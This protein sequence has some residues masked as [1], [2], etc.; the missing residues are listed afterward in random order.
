M[1]RFTRM[2][3]LIGQDAA[4]RLYRAKVAV[5]GLGGVGGYVVEALARAG[6]GT[7]VIIDG[8]KIAESNINRQIIALSSTVGLYKT[9]AFE[10][11]IADINQ[12]AKVIKHTLFYSADNA[13]NV[14]L[15]GCDYVADAI[16][17]VPSKIE[18]IKRA[19]SL[20]IPVISAM[21]AGNKLRGDFK[22]ADIA[23]TKV[24]PLARIVR[25]ELKNAGVTGVKAAYS[26][27]IP[28]AFA[29]DGK[30]RAPASISYVPPSMGLLIAGEI[31]RDMIGNA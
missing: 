11:R 4:N 15:S 12:N 5:F 9:D 18:I 19:K 10:K 23:A 24:C 6:V 1:D 7:L 3:N 2:E 26:E 22:I 29:S 30:E 20:N 25:R 31:I 21:G 16:D 17:S 13:G 27:E 8:D 14:D 28:A